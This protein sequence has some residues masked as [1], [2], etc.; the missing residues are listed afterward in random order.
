MKV[1]KKITAALLVMTVMLVAVSCAAQDA[2]QNTT[3]SATESTTSGTSPAEVVKRADLTAGVIPDMISGKTLTESDVEKLAEV[4]VDLFRSTTSKDKKSSL[5]SPLSIITALGMTADGAAGNTKAQFEKLFGMTTEQLDAAMNYYYGML[6]SSEKAKF[7][8]ANSIWYTSRDDFTVKESFISRVLGAYYPQL[9]TVDFTDKNTVD[10]INRWVKEHT[11]EMIDKIVD[12]LDPT[13]LM[14]LINALVFDAK[15]SMPYDEYMVN[16]GTFNAYNGEKQTVSMMSSQEH[17]YIETADATGFVKYYEGGD[18]KFVALLPDKDVDVF[19]FVDSLDGKTLIDAVKNVSYSKV[20]A[21]MPKFS[22]DYDISLKETLLSLGLVDAF[23]DFADFTEMFEGGGACISDV[24]HKTHI[25][26]DNAGTKAAAVTAV[27]M[28][29]TTSFNPEMPKS[30]VLDRPFV[31]FI[32]DSETDLPI[33]MGI[34]TE[35]G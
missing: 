21:R 15:W 22:Y 27:I 24:I 8:Y 34:V 12:D 20:N 2:P 32:V 14:V 25:D 30:V 28:V 13:T 33:F 31:Y 1:I 23:D 16:D 9:Y 19:D 4:Y 6:K 26:V 35:V 11:D 3:Q 5:I 17:E 7:D 10:E 18:Y 29:E